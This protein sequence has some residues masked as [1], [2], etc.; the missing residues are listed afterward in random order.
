V[1]IIAAGYRAR[2]SIAVPAVAFGAGADAIEV[3]ASRC[4]E[5]RRGAHRNSTRAGETPALW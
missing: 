4:G 2:S 5:F 1:V 3:A